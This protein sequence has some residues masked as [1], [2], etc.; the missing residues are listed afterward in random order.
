MPNPF[1]LFP[2][3]EQ[4]QAQNFANR[5]AALARFAL[6]PVIVMSLIPPLSVLLAKLHFTSAEI[7]FHLLLLPPPHKA[8]YCASGIKICFDRHM[9]LIPFSGTF[10]LYPLYLNVQCVQEFRALIRL[11]AFCE[12]SVGE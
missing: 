11:R 12:W 1:C 6:S 3:N 2:P 5:S 8:S 9:P 7:A 10:H 4:T